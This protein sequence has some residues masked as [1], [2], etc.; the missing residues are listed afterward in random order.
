MGSMTKDSFT[1]EGVALDRLVLSY[2]V[3]RIII[4]FFYLLLNTPQLF[5]EFKVLVKTN[6]TLTPRFIVFFSLVIQPI[7][8]MLGCGF[9]IR[10]HDYSGNGFEQISWKNKKRVWNIS[11]CLMVG[12]ILWGVL[13]NIMSCVST[14]SAAG[15]VSAAGFIVCLVGVGLFLAINLII[16]SNHLKRHKEMMLQNDKHSKSSYKIKKMA[17]LLVGTIIC[18]AAR[19]LWLQIGKP[20]Y[21]DNIRHLSSFI[22]M[23]IE[24]FQMAVV[25]LGVANHPY[26]Y[27]LFR[28]VNRSKWLGDSSAVEISQTSFAKSN[29]QQI[30]M[31]SMGKSI[32]T[33]SYIEDD[34]D[35]DAP[36]FNQSDNINNNNNNID[37]A[38]GGDDEEMSKSTFTVKVDQ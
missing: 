18:V 2:Y 15:M 24:F 12:M 32:N 3:I 16:L 17:W 28:P 14:A 11:L 4:S 6:F 36:V 9:F 22:T 8:R 7:M 34:L 5:Y 33:M 1:N 23:L 27:L 21:N 19:E 29:Q 31:A 20:G 26:N 10:D 37:G 38:G 30:S 35:Y 13:E 25:M